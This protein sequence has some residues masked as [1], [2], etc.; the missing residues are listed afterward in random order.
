MKNLC[1]LL[2]I[3]SIFIFNSCGLLKKNV[4][5]DIENID[6]IVRIDERTMQLNDSLLSN[7][8]NYTSLALNFVG[9]YDSNNSEI[10]IKGTIRIKKNDFIWISLRPVAGIEIA[11]VLLTND[12]IHFLDRM[13]KEYISDDYSLIESIYG[14]EMDYNTLQALLTNTL[15]TYPPGNSIDQY[16]V[17]KDEGVTKSFNASGIYKGNNLSHTIT[18]SSDNWYIIQTFVKILDSGKEIKIKYEKF[19]QI[20]K[21]KFPESISVI[22]NNTG[23]ESNINFDYKSIDINK[24]FS[25]QFTIPESYKKVSLEK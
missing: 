24:N 12:S 5:K 8:L 16:F 15:F 2:F 25:R 11:R 9:N 3:A 17:L 23:N 19:K 22:I 7:E 20:S 10:P 21:R 14:M 4:K 18:F 13:K 1:F 6:D